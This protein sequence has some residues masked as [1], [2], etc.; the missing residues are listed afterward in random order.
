MYVVVG[1][2]VVAVAVVVISLYLALL[3]VDA[4]PLQH[5]SKS[6]LATSCLFVLLRL[7]LL[8]VLPFLLSF[9]VCCVMFS[10]HMVALCWCC[11]WALA[12]WLRV[13]LMW[14]VAVGGDGV[15]VVAYAMRVCSWLAVDCV[16]LIV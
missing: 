5:V 16:L 1:C 7:L 6:R 4:A 9:I 13:L 14:F 2:V 3:N 10:D 11:C 15:V 8:C 12:S